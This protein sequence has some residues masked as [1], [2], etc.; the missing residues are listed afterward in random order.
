LGFIDLDF[1]E[2]IKLLAIFVT[3]PPFIQLCML[4]RRLPPWFADLAWVRLLT[5]RRN[6][7]YVGGRPRDSSMLP[8]QPDP[9]LFAP[10]SQ[11]MDFDGMPERDTTLE[12]NHLD[13]PYRGSPHFDTPYKGSPGSSRAPSYS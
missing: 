9:T 7:P 13:L 1:D 5:C 6:K 12:M 3:V 11:K 8:L 10:L 4:L 2:T